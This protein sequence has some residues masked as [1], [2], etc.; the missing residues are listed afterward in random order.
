MRK[1]AKRSWS[2]TPSCTHNRPTTR[3]PFLSTIVLVLWVGDSKDSMYLACSCLSGIFS[4]E[5]MACRLY[6]SYFACACT[7]RACASTRVWGGE[8][9][10]NKERDQRKMDKFIPH[11]HIQSIPD[12]TLSSDAIA[13]MKKC[14]DTYFSSCYISHTIHTYEVW[15]Y[16]ISPA[17]KMCI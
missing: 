9:K 7:A 5:E 8:K 10:E 3:R 16:V 17:K 2:S 15:K 1:L 11:T 6:Q 13:K 12:L 14:Q 4:R